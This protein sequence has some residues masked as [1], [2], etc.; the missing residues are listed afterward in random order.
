MRCS[1]LLDDGGSRG[2]SVEP[3]A[4]LVHH[5]SIV[6]SIEG[7][8]VCGPGADFVGQLYRLRPG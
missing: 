2:K 3:P 6:L 4:H 8:V 1:F 5:V 7:L